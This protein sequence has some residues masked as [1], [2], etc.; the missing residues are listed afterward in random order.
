MFRRIAL[1]IPGGAEALFRLHPQELNILLE[2]AWEFRVHKNSEA[3]GHPDRRSDL[4]QLPRKILDLFPFAATNRSRFVKSVV[5]GDSAGTVRWGHLVYPYLIENTNICEIFRKVLFEL[6]HGESLGVPTAESQHWMRNTEELFFK[7]PAPYSIHSVVSQIRPDWQAT[8]R[9]TYY[10]M[11]GS[12]L[13]H[14]KEY[15]FVKPEAANIDFFKSVWE[16]FIREVWVGIA[17][18]ENESGTNPTDKHTIARIAKQLHDML[19]TRRQNGNLARE[20]FYAVSM[21]SW[22]HLTVEFNSP[23]VTALRAEG[24]SPEQR[25]FKIA[26]RVNLPAHGKAEDLFRLADPM[27]RIFTQIETGIYNDPEAVPALYLPAD[28]GPAADM[29]TIV[30]AY[31]S[32]TGRN[33]KVRKAA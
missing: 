30:S 19:I 20:E 8:R 23:I 18:A 21:M 6:L 16:N 13:N 27:S 2:L 9:T 26:E 5:N 32:A 22:F 12:L 11:F 33:M 29:G 31:S 7:D 3:L 24:S 17:N 28:D 14:D 15:Q 10:R 1:E 25:L 4:S